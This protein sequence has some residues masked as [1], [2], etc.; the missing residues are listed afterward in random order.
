MRESNGVPAPIDLSVRIYNRLLAVYPGRFRAEYGQP[1][2]Q[3]FRDVC[4]R[5]Y[6]RHGWP[7]VASLWARTSLDLVRTTVEEHLKRGLDMNREEFVR[8]S[9]WALMAGAILFA[10]GMMLAALTSDNS[11]TRLEGFYEV[12]GLV[13]ILLGEILVVIGLLGLRAGFAGP[14]DELGGI[15]LVMAIIG[16]VGFLAGALGFLAGSPEGFAWNAWWLGW[17]TMSLGLAA[18]GVLAIRHHLFSRWNFAPLLAGAI[19]PSV[20]AAFLALGFNW[21]LLVLC[22]PLISIGL[23]LIGYR[24]QADVGGTSELAV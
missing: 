1:M 13:G 21:K 15:L 12:G 20:F 9:G 7:G 17:L 22:M 10:A 5:D 16:G 24:M 6:R 23:I 2:V 18:Y 3:L 4:R 14:K 8:W 11:I 19:F